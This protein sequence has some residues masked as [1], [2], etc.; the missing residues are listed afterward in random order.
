MSMFV[1]VAVVAGLG[2]LAVSACTVSV[3]QMTCEEVATEALTLAESQEEPRL[4][5]IENG[6]EVSRTEDRI[7]CSG[8]GTYSGGQQAQTTY[9]LFRDEAGD[10]RV[11]YRTGP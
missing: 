4:V 7:T 3:D 8:D 11:E 10:L 6:V 9:E 5:S 2:S 1:R